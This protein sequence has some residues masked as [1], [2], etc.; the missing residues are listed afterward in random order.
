MNMYNDTWYS[1]LK[2]IPNIIKESLKVLKFKSIEVSKY[3]K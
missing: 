1:T 2:A 3:G